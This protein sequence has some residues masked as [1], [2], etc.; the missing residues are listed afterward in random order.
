MLGTLKG[1]DHLFL[2]L[3]GHKAN[4]HNIHASLRHH[5]LLLKTPHYGGRSVLCGLFLRAVGVVYDWHA[6]K[7]RTLSFQNLGIQ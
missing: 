5:H 3:P 6:V 2:D 1:G 7:K 4:V